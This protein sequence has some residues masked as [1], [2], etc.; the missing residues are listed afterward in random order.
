VVGEGLGEANIISL[1][2][3]GIPLFVPARLV[4]KIYN[5]DTSIQNIPTHRKTCFVEWIGIMALPLL[6]WKLLYLP[7]SLRIDLWNGKGKKSS[8]DD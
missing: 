7:K 5:A 3:D 6:V 2:P 1:A 8:S 4:R